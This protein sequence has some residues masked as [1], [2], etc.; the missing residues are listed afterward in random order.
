MRSSHSRLA[1]TIIV[2]LF[3]AAACTSAA[4]PAPATTPAPSPVVTPTPVPTTVVT[5][6]APPS[7]PVPTPSDS[8]PVSCEPV[9]AD[10]ACPA[11]EALLPDSVEGY[12]LKKESHTAD[13]IYE[14]PDPRLVGL[15][16]EPADLT[17][18]FGWPSIAGRIIS[19]WVQRLDGVSG[20]ELLAATLEGMGGAGVS[21][22]SLGGREVTLVTGGTVPVWYYATDD[23]LFLIQ[24]TGQDTV[25]GGEETV[26]RI[27]AGLP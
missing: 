9:S 15:G 14:R 11:L 27:L 12:P 3:V 1:T 13:Q 25:A 26:A 24:A 17:I 4:T 19:V 5:P 16:K 6:T 2:G 22:T 8:I 7:N 18:A 20:G 21:Q 10:H 23:L